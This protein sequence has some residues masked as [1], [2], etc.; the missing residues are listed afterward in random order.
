MQLSPRQVS[1]IQSTPLGEA[2]YVIVEKL[3]EKGFDAWWVGGCVRDILLEKEPKDIDIGTDA[4]PEQIAMILKVADDHGKQFGSIVVQEKGYEIEVTT[5]REDDEASDGRH[6][7]SV[8]FS[9]R[10]HDAARRDFTVNALYF[11]PITR[12]LFD[13]FGGVEDLRERLVRFIGEPGVRIKHDALRMLRAIRLRATLAGQYHPETYRALLELAS[14]IETLSPMRQFEELEKLLLCPAPNRGF[15]DLW[16]TGILKYTI[17]ELFA[18]RGVAQ[19]KDF[20]HEGDVWEHILK[21]IAA[22]LP[23]HSIDTRLATLFHDCGKAETFSVRDR[24]HFD[25]HASVSADI[26]S[27]VLTRLQVGKKRIEKIDW[28]IRHHMSM[29]TF[30][31][32]QISRKHHWYYHPWFPELLSL[33]WLDI[34]GTEPSDYSLYNKIVQDYHLFLD[35]NPKPIKLF[36]TGEE[37]METLGVSPGAKVGEVL[38]MLKRE[39]QEKRISKRKEAIEWLKNLTNN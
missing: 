5:F 8:V 13:P 18:C 7:E 29:T 2:G 22:F 11:H 30:L 14:H 25:H 24:I 9:D 35:A 27:K 10:A 17:P 6:P 32:L 39:Q 37:V 33:F 16:E 19:P 31:D 3:F 26:A 15:E 12:E 4:R 23:E 28:L 21:C 38:E 20:H 36:L 34:A 1:A